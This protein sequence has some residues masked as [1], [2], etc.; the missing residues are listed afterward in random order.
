MCPNAVLAPNRIGE[1][2]FHNLKRVEEDVTAPHK[3][4]P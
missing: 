1:D 2:V 3:T 4:M